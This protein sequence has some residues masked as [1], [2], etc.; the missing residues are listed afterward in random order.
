MFLE[1]LPAKAFN[2]DALNKATAYVVL[3]VRVTVVLV[4]MF[5]TTAP[6]KVAG[7]AIDPHVGSSIVVAS[8]FALSTNGAK[9]G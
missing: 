5:L 4:E 6:T 7:C 3:R 9:F 8:I 1:M 2:R